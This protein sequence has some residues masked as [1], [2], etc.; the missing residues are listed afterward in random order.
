MIRYHSYFSNVNFMQI[1]LMEK[2]PPL[3]PSNSYI[4]GCQELFNQEIV[5][6]PPDTSIW[7]TDF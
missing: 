2:M 6:L 3:L 1:E 5:D 7:L 4:R